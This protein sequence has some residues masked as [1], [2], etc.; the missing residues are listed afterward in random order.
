MQK[1]NKKKWVTPK[2]ELMTHQSILSK[3]QVPVPEQNKTSTGATATA[4]AS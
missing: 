1:S 4:I 2:L 3:E